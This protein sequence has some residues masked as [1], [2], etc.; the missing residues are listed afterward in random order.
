MTQQTTTNSVITFLTSLIL[1]CSATSLD[2][3]T[4][5][6]SQSEFVFHADT[7]DFGQSFT[8]EQDT[9]IVGIRLNLSASFGGSDITIRIYDFDRS[10]LSFVSGILARGTLLE[11]ALSTTPAWFDVMVDDRVSLVA[12]NAY[13]FTVE[14][15]DPGGVDTGWNNYAVTT[16]DVYPGGEF[17]IEFL[18][19]I[20]TN[21]NLKELAFETL[22]IP[23]PSSLLL[24]AFALLGLIGFRLRRKRLF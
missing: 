24:A 18:G 4:I 7:L 15:K 13:A 17:F 8:S 11:S 20:T 23:E 19:S 6:I 12:G 2:A 1:I 16:V 3:A 9:D 21:T 22:I 14:A 5:G 10:T